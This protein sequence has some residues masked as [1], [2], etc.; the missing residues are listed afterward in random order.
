M[1]GAAAG[2]AEEDT[3]WRAVGFDRRRWFLREA[4][5]RLEA[6]RVL[7]SAHLFLKRGKVIVRLL[8]KLGRGIVDLLIVF[9]NLGPLFVATGGV[10][11]EL[12][13]LWPHLETR[14]AR[15]RLASSPWPRTKMRL[16]QNREAVF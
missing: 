3:G 11:N 6:R 2:V 1:P 15:G 4:G 16:I 12:F 10:S 8:G 14:L 7:D 9:D 13:H 5:R